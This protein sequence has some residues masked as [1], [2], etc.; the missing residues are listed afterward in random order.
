MATCYPALIHS[1]I[2]EKFILRLMI[3]LVIHDTLHVFFYNTFVP[4]MPIVQF[5]RSLPSRFP[6]IHTARSVV[7]FAS[8][9]LTFGGSISASCIDAQA[10]RDV[11][12]LLHQNVG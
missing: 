5:V 11:A 9:R 2:C 4:H 12:A 3:E 6:C 8:L 7:A 10:E 1:F